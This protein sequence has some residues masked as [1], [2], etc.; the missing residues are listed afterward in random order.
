MAKP[1]DLAE[2]YMK[3]FFGQA[4]LDMMNEILA[5]DLVF[6][7]PFH[8]SSTAKA[9]IESLRE[10]PPGDVHYHLENA[11]ED[12]NTACLVYLFYKP[13]VETRMAQRFEIADGKICK[14]S[15]VFD[16]SAFT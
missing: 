11:Y 16:T 3:S 7:G 13:G 2:I 14:I 6:E 4:P 5:E 15:L 10:N 12:E 9:Y 8:K 1:L